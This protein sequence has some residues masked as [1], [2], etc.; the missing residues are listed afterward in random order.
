MFFPFLNALDWFRVSLLISIFRSFFHLEWNNF[1]EMRRFKKILEWMRRFDVLVMSKK[2]IKGFFVFVSFVK[3]K[4]EVWF[5]Y[6]NKD[7]LSIISFFILTKWSF[8]LPNFYRCWNSQFLFSFLSFI[9]FFSMW[10][11]TFYFNLM[12]FITFLLIFVLL[13]CEIN[14]FLWI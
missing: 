12:L 7:I 11:I 14:F 5:Y 10:W 8:G 6:T 2:F 9:E 3:M 1:E 13:K 4:F